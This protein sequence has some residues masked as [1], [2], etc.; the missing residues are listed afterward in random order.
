MTISWSYILAPGHIFFKIL[1]NPLVKI[2][3]L[4]FIVFRAHVGF[5]FLKLD[6]NI[7]KL[8]LTAMM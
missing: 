8:C 6:I 2:E 7:K 4:T 1:Q 5:Y 3:K